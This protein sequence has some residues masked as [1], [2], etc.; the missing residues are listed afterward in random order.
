MATREEG[1]IL[2]VTI[3]C[4]FLIAGIALLLQLQV[5]AGVVL[6][7]GTEGQLH[8]MVL[9]SNGVEYACSI[10]PDQ[11]RERLLSGGL[12]G[13]TCGGSGSGERNPFDFN[14]A[15]TTSL[16]ELKVHCDDGWPFVDTHLLNPAGWGSDRAGKFFVRFSEV[17][18]SLG[19]TNGE[20]VYLVRSMGVVPNRLPGFTGLLR[21]HV[22]LLEA[23]VRLDREFALEGALTM[24]AAGAE[25][26]T[27]AGIEH[28]D[29][30]GGAAVA[31]LGERSEFLRSAVTEQL[32]EGTTTPL[33]DALT[34]ELLVDLTAEWMV[35][36]LHNR[37]F[38][39][40]FWS[41]FMAS[42]G[43]FGAP[44]ASEAQ[45]GWKLYWL[46]EGGEVPDGAKGVLVA[47]GD[48]GLLSGTS[49]KGL[50]LHLG[51]GRV[52][53]EEGARVKGAV[54]MSDHSPESSS[55]A[56]ELTLGEVRLTLR[57][58]SLIEFDRD[59]VV[60]AAAVFPPTLIRWRIIFPEM[61]Q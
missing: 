60:R 43:D 42:I 45:N 21:N 50:L 41:H 23:T 12:D 55:G 30:E 8:S 17:P 4:V 46:P 52:V 25:I 9:A 24:M 2:I 13:V 39:G 18:E 7:A 58:N 3:V 37:L 27:V 22:T 29:G 1:F 11:D 36:P 6:T 32:G 33:G 54:W 57:R 61:K 38:S 40:E 16:G 26:E 28:L 56:G 49:F 15:Q 34:S 20:N 35:D 31:F 51:G 5:A 59:I 10:L 44:L 19:D 47:R 48:L 14:E 53:F